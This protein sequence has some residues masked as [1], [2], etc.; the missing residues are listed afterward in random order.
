MRQADHSLACIDLFWLPLVVVEGTS[1]D[2]NA[3]S[4]AGVMFGL[5]P[6]DRF[7]HTFADK[8]S[9]PDEL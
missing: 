6:S 1:I 2:H 8:G 3:F 5:H 4:S 9:L 7:M